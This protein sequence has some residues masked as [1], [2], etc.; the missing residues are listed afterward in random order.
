MTISKS[1][2]IVIS[3]VM[4]TILLLFQFSNISANYV[5]KSMYNQNAEEHVSI[6]S[7]QILDREVLELPE[8]YNTAIIGSPR[9]QEANIAEEWCI[10]TKR[11]YQR[12][13]N[14]REFI[15]NPSSYCTMII[16]NSIS[17]CTKKD[18]DILYHQSKLG[19]N[20]ILTSL[21]NTTFIRSSEKFKR[22][23]GIRGVYQAT[24]RI[25]GMTL[26]DGFLLGGKTTYKKLEKS[27]PYF[28][29]RSGT[30]TYITG[31]IKRQKELNIKNEDLPPLLW[32][33]QT[34]DSF[35]F[36]VN[37]DFFQDHTGLGMLSAML[38]EAMP[39][40]IYPIVNAQ[41]VVCQNFPYLSNE[42][43][44]K[45]AE[46]YYY[47][48]KAL[49]ENV[50]W[51]DMVS[52]LNATEE[53][54]SGMIAPKLEYSNK[55]HNVST[56]S[57]SFYFDQNEKISG[58]LGLSGDQME[59]LARYEDKIKYDTEAMAKLA[60][61]YKFTVFS[62]GNMPEFIYKH[63]LGEK[64]QDSILSSIRTLITKKGLDTN[65]II[66]FYDNKI[67]QMT[68][69]IDGFSHKDVEDLYL[70]SIETALGYSSIY[71]D[72][73]RAIY[74]TKRG[75]DWTR[76]SNN[77]S[78]YLSTYWRTFRKGFDQVTVSE[79]DKKARRFLALDYYSQREKDSIQLNIVNIKENASF[80]LCLND[81]KV[82][83]VKGAEYI[84]MERGKYV[85][86]TSSDKV[87]IEVAADAVK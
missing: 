87:L 38:S 5:S 76:L 4:I 86:N 32:R 56:D 26:Y 44:E 67:L 43:S 20:I 52:I 28:R 41:N 9:N 46:H 33:N 2:F 83:S 22:L 8:N 11:T 75:D 40:N 78:R 37:C 70:K 7:T 25:S 65:P 24:Y 34:E 62:P 47:T 51:P 1:N 21:P 72:F 30:K 3:T 14:L 79:S 66:S 85:I 73:T 23:I 81:E 19:I 16:L 45:T 6:S 12:F 57:I 27:V 54:F 64:G 36:V 31:Y 84:E 42:N 39:Y 58:D 18:V 15:A 10:Y 60:P 69:T 55:E 63:Y 48:S 35:V 13:M 74:P 71:L 82:V 17:V 29:L 50:L 80:L 77:L 53:K 68:T 59:N 61:H 49:C